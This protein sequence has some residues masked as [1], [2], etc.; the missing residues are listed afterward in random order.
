MYNVH[1]DDVPLPT[2][3]QTTHHDLAIFR[4]R[5]R[6]EAFILSIEDEQQ[7]SSHDTKNPNKR[8]VEH[9]IRTRL[10]Y[11]IHYGQRHATNVR[12]LGVCTA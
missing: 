8:A 7:H 11:L 4:N 5:P 12:A 2:L 3:W 6:A 9:P 1:V 10:N